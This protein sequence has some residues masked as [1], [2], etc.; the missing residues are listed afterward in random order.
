MSKFKKGDKVVVV[1]NSSMSGKEKDSSH[2]APA[3]FDIVEVAGIGP[4]GMVELEFSGS[5][6]WATD[7][8]VHERDF[9]L[10]CINHLFDKSIELELFYSDTDEFFYK[11]RLGYSARTYTTKELI[12]T[13][14]PTE[15]PQQKKLKELEEQQ[16]KIAAEMQA[17]RESMS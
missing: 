13:L 11:C 6:S 3:L 12:D 4:A 5:I 9:T 16:R 1:D 2:R 14:Y 7:R 15:T 8:F 10:A 17:L